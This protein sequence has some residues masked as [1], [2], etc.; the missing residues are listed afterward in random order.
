MPAVGQAVPVPFTSSNLP[1]VLIDT[2]NQPI[3]DDPK[4]TARLRIINHGP[5]RRNLLTDTPNQYKGFI[6][7]ELRGASSQLMPKKSYGFETRTADGGE[8][9]TTLLGMPA[10]HDWVL[11]A[12]YA[13][14]TLLRNSLAYELARQQGQY[15]SRSHYCEVVLNGEYIGVYVLGEKVKRGSSRVNIGKMK[16]TDATGDAVTGGYLF[17]SDRPVVKPANGFTSKHHNPSLPDDD[18]QF[19]EVEYPKAKDLSPAQLGYLSA[20]VDSFEVALE[21]PDFANPDRGYRRYLD[22]PSFID[23]Y[24]LTELSRNVD[25]FASST[26]FYK[27][28]NSKGGKLTAGPAWDFDL[29]WHNADYA[30]AY[31]PEGWQHEYS[32]GRWNTGPFW[33]RRLL[34]DT[35]FTNQ[36]NKR[37]QSL[38]ATAF[39]EE[40]LFRYI[41]STAAALE[42][43]Q[44]RNFQAWPIMGQHVWPNPLPVA[45]TYADEISN[46]KHWIQQRLSWIDA[47]LPGNVASTITATSPAR[48]FVSFSSFPVPFDTQLRVRYELRQ[49]GPVHVELL[50]PIGTLVHRQQ[51][52]AQAAGPH[53][54][55]V[56]NLAAVP[57]GVYFLR[58]TSGSSSQ[59]L[60][61][62]KTAQ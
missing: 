15:A 57:A 59:T 1:I 33:R 46:L 10:E 3:V 22:V 35:T 18:G 51:L 7:I 17:K 48:P 2:Q 52:P 8:L 9:D 29:A 54:A 5:G 55:E 16:S 60:R 30:D 43:G 49:A 4:I 45:A 50:S 61:V 34:D 26:Y 62:Q 21:G 37:W 27:D 20:Y 40:N 58:L 28:K 13:D 12:N 6:G 53:E 24:L 39:R 23:F 11:T 14:K 56:A 36:L 42:E 44:R 32:N 38:R 19:F 25:G 31:L 47:N 41:D